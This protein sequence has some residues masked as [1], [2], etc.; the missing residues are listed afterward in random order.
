MQLRGVQGVQGYHC[1]AQE[2]DGVEMEGGGF[3]VQMR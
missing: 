1:Q 2:D 3:P